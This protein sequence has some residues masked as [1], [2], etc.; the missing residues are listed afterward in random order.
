MNVLH[1][2]PTPFFADRGCH[3]RICNEIEALQKSGVNVTLCTYNLGRDIPGIDIRRIWRIPGYTQ[4]G[5][6][7]SPFKFIADILLF[8]LV[9]KIAWQERPAILHGHLHEGALLGW[10]VKLC[11]FW[12]RM[13]LIMDMQGSLS[14][15]LIGYGTIKRKSWLAR[16]VMTVEKAICLLPDLFFCS[17]EKSMQLLKHTFRVAP[18]KVVL[19]NDV[20]PDH[21]FRPQ[22]QQEARRQ[23]GIPLDRTVVLYSGSLL[24][25]KGVDYIVR[26]I[27]ELRNQRPELYFLLVGYPVDDIQRQLA[28]HGLSECLHLTGQVAYRDLPQ[29]LAVADL[30]LDPKKENSGEASGKILHYMAAALPVICFDTSNNRSILGDLGYYAD[31]QGKNSFATAIEL[32]SDDCSKLRY[33]RGHRGRA[34]IK[35]RHSFAAIHTIMMAKYRSLSGR[36]LSS[37]GFFWAHDDLLGETGEMVISLSIMSE[38]GMTLINLV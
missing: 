38:F 2:A 10:A 9:L 12:R 11:L 18:E 33:K 8:F 24:P 22:K 4:L 32:A 6:G 30:A 13:P 26:S 21:F 37:L 20:V 14:G 5:A 16:L 27:Q 31:R 7:F 1:I 35:R 29:W 17:S 19:L 25:G 23:L 36:R 3:I 34:I 28:E 15:E